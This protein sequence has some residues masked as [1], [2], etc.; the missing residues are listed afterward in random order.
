MTK[1]KFDFRVFSFISILKL[2]LYSYDA[3]LIRPKEWYYFEVRLS[4][5]LEIYLN[6]FHY[7]FNKMS[8]LKSSLSISII[9]YENIQNSAF[10]RSNLYKYYTFIIACSQLRIC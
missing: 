10:L 9:K 8:Q 7:L 2:A 6:N 1:A 4:E 5:V 3:Q